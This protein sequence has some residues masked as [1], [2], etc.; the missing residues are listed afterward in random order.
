MPFVMA[1]FDSRIRRGKT[2]VVPG[3]GNSFLA[4]VEAVFGGEGANRKFRGRFPG[5][6]LRIV[7]AN[8]MQPATSATLAT[9][10]RGGVGS[11]LVSGILDISCNF[12]ET[13]D[14]IFIIFSFCHLAYRLD[15]SNIL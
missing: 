1:A 4:C 10:A 5:R 13:S 11:G 8:T 6:K 3:S 7:F 14:S 12:V 2:L 15:F 9:F